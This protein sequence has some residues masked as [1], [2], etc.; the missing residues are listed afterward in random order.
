MLVNIT[1]NMISYYSLPPYLS[2][3]SNGPIF[4]AGAD[5]F[6]SSDCNSH[7]GSYS[8]LGCSYSCST[9]PSLTLANSKYFT[10]E[11]YEVYGL[12]QDSN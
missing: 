8:Q 9:F 11:E 6:I 3:F 12:R 2:L 5:L 10:V 7:E 1:M 4:G